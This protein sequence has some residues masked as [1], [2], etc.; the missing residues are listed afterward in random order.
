MN[1]AE[2]SIREF[3]AFRKSLIEKGKI[4]ILCELEAQ[5]IKQ[6]QEVAIAYESGEHPWIYRLSRS[7]HDL[8][9]S[10]FYDADEIQKIIAHEGYAQEDVK[11]VIEEVDEQV[12][13]IA[14]ELIAFFADHRD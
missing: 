14:T 1:A 3:V 13:R 5:K 10:T 7:Y 9:G 2:E 4:D 8:A 12:R 11:R 6:L